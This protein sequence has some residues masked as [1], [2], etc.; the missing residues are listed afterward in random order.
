MDAAVPPWA[1]QPL[2][3]AMIAFPCV[4]LLSVLLNYSLGLA[5]G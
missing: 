2:A 3:G 1:A 5:S 4:L